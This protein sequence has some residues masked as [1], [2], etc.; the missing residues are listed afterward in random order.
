VVP[1]NVPE[2]ALGVR[3]LWVAGWWGGGWGAEAAAPP[4]G[5]VCADARWWEDEAVGGGTR[6]WWCASVAGGAS[7]VPSSLC[8]CMGRAWI[9]GRVMAG[10]GGGGVGG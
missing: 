3:V 5:V 7:P 2:E 4:A 10:V 9:R 6:S 8:T 1:S